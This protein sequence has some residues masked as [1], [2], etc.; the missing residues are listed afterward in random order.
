MEPGSM[1]FVFMIFIIASI[2]GVAAIGGLVWFFTRGE[3]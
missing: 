3:A 1:S 2:V